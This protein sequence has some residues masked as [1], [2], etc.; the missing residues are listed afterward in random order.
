MYVAARASSTSRSRLASWRSSI[1]QTPV[2][3]A[4]RVI[5]VRHNR[6][7]FPCGLVTTTR[8]TCS[9]RNARFGATKSS[10]TRPLQTGRRAD[11][12]PA[13]RDALAEE[14]GGGSAQAMLQQHGASH[15]SKESLEIAGYVV[16]FTT[17]PRDRMDATRC[18]R[19]YDC[20]GRSSCNSSGGNRVRLRPVTELP[21]T[22]SS[23][24]STQSFF[25]A[26][27][28]MGSVPSETRFPPGAARDD[29]EAGPTTTSSTR[30]ARWRGSLGNSRASS[31]HFYSPPSL[32]DALTKLPAL[33]ARLPPPHELAAAAAPALRTRKAKMRSEM[34]C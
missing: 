17:V 21:T 14:A 5:L 3:R 19:A 10:T 31:I 8:L 22:R 33:T 20:G 27:C 7:R 2:R 30:R 4:S 34:S 6:G 13:D 26:S 18:P 25:S 1:A 32:R 28:S 12:R 9:Q 29:R 15:V 23:R 11:R 16:L 24:G